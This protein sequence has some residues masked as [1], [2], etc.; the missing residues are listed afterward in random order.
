MG[1]PPAYIFVVRH[2]NRLDAADKQWHLSSPTPYDPPLTYGGWMHSRTVGARIAA[3]L[4]D[5]AETEIERKAVDATSESVPSIS[6][7]PLLS[8]SPK[9]RRRRFRVVI[10]SSPFLRCV[11]T[12]VAISAGLASNP[13]TSSSS[14][15]TADALPSPTHR[16]DLRLT[17]AS[18]FSNPAPTKTRPDVPVPA[19]VSLQEASN[20]S[21]STE[22]SVLR[23]DAFLGE[24]LSPDYFEHITPPPKSALM[25]ATAKAELLR[26]SSYHDYPHF[27]AR[28]HSSAS[29]Q[30]WGNLSSHNGILGTPPVHGP[31]SISSLDTLSHL[32]GSLTDHESNANG[33]TDSR[34]LHGTSQGTGHSAGYVYPVPS[35]ALSTSEPIPKGYVAHARDACVSVDYQWDSSRESLAWG[36]GGVLPEEWAAMHHRFRKG[37][38]RLV[39]W[40][41]ST[42]DAGAMVTR[43]SNASHQTGTHGSIDGDEDTEIEDVVVLVSHGAGCN[44]LIGALTQQPVLADIA[45]SSLTVAKRRASFD[46]R[47]IN[48]TRE[49]S[50]TSL[51]TALP[52]S[53][54][55]MPEIY[56]LQLFA[57]TDHLTSS[58]PTGLSRSTSLGGPHPRVSRVHSGYTSALKDINFGSLYG[59]SSSGSRGHSSNASLGSMRRPSGPHSLVM[60]PSVYNANTGGSVS[61]FSVTR[62]D[63]SGSGT[64]GLWSP[65]QEENE[66]EKEL[67]APMFLDFSHEKTVKDKDAKGATLNNDKP[68]SLVDADNAA[69]TTTKSDGEKSIAHNQHE[70]CE[71]H[72]EERD[73]FDQ[74]SVPQRWTSMSSG[75]WGAPRPPGEAERLR[76]FSSTKRRWTVTER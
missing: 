9:R 27:H 58:S 7:S 64:W 3:I 72:E 49:K 41:G 4:R 56:E 53:R 54:A 12:S 57:N 39:D 13:T 16:G 32:A 29:S 63:R 73:A 37:L 11:Q 1:R 42:E 24:W 55:T 2:G 8:P 52:M 22:K 20:A 62:P 71:H 14:L 35:Y 70:I 15:K 6:T 23:L 48:L 45:M 67:E 34:G 17:Q 43:T 61:S 44:A 51:H 19:S 59:G 21:R 33:H 75:L 66:H 46:P 50:L 28:V 38:R 18:S 26:R 68:L 47:N 36:D 31:H 65:K 60:G 25:L 10:H 30:L 69:Y 74:D 40:Y 76:D 5:E